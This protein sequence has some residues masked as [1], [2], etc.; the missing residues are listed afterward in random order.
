MGWAIA[1]D[2]V[3]GHPQKEFSQYLSGQALHAWRLTFVHPVSGQVI[4]NTAPLPEG[5]EKL[6][7]LLRRRC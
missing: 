2:P 7:T 4:E 6:L 3:Y 5:F 1:C